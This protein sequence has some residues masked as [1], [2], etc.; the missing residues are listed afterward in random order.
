M[1]VPEMSSI[2]RQLFYYKKQNR[3]WFHVSLFV[4]NKVSRCLFLFISVY[5]G[6]YPLQICRWHLFMKYPFWCIWIFGSS[7][8]LI[9]GFWGRFVFCKKFIHQFKWFFIHL[10]DKIFQKFVLTSWYFIITFQ[11]LNKWYT[12]INIP[13]VWIIIPSC[14]N[15]LNF[16]SNMWSHRSAIERCP[17][18]WNR[19]H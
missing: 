8:T 4:V 13:W 7:T 19:L 1:L 15:I 5:L 10:F 9:S 16:V 6:K 11:I 18:P 2:V 3:N 12:F 14:K 17:S